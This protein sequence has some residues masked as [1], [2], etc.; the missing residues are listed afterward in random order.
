M[1]FR[2]RFETILRQ[3]QR[4]VDEIAARYAKAM[5][6]VQTERDTLA[7]LADAQD[8]YR[9]RYAAAL[10]PGALF[11]PHLQTGV[12]YAAFLERALVEQ[13]Q[14]IGEMA[15]R[16]EQIRELLVE[17]ERAKQVFANLKE[18]WSA[19]YYAD[20]MAKDRAYFDGIANTAFTA[21]HQVH[22]LHGGT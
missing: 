5:R 14:R 15:R 1:G 13:H 21:K 17:A 12:R 18:R 3:K 19:R 10:E 6:L 2:F 8:T 22:A 7:V 4:A 16:A 20:L 11:V 9:G